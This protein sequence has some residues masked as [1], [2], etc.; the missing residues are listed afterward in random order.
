M[1]TCLHIAAEV[2]GYA[3]HWTR[4]DTFFQYKEKLFANPVVHTVI[5]ESDWK[6]NYNFPI[7]PVA[8]APEWRARARVTVSMHSTFVLGGP[9]CS[10]GSGLFV[11]MLSRIND[12]GAENTLLVME[13]TLEYLCSEGYFKGVDE[14]YWVT[15]GGPHYSCKL[16]LS[17]MGS[18]WT[19]Q[20][21]K[22]NGSM[23]RRMKTKQ[24]KIRRS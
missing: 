17:H 4:R 16:V 2:A 1:D 13:D 5:L 24:K 18:R 20:L 15:D 22:A 7:G 14:V 8:S 10:G 19:E 23:E 6:E 12:K 11:S 9:K 3:N 21:R